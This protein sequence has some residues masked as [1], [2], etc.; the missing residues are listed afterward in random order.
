MLPEPATYEV[1]FESTWSAVTHP[2]AFPPNPHFSG[3]I[4]ATHNDQV[5][6][7]H[8]G[9]TASD[10]IESMAE[11]GRK[12]ALIALVETAMTRGRIGALLSG[13]GIRLSPG[14]VRL[15]FEMTAE[16]PQVTLVSMLAPSPDW[17]VGVAG[18][19]L[20]E[21]GAWVEE[22]TIELYAYDAGTDSGSS[23][24]AP[25]ED[26]APRG[27][28]TRLESGVFKVGDIVPPVGRFTFIR[29]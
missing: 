23:Y 18:L 2:E 4:G 20:L 17:F 14:V 6:F 28:I 7:W 1:I 26:T 9:G 15:T 25:D 12:D 19:N 3:L 11:T 21:D 16:H 8:S 29:R 27:T 24:T 22:E 5:I 13:D 10:G